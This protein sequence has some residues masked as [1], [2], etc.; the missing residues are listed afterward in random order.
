MPK[1]LL[2]RPRLH[3]PSLYVACYAVPARTTGGLQ[4]QARPLVWLLFEVALV[5]VPA[6]FVF[7]FLSDSPT[8][9]SI[10]I[11]IRIIINSFKLITTLLPALKRQ[12][13]TSWHT[14]ISSRVAKLRLVML[15][16]LLVANGTFLSRS[17]MSSGGNGVHA[18]TISTHCSSN[19][20]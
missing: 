8:S 18:L 3:G 19:R 2:S 16:A 13:L 12:Q 14:I 7:F 17:E 11:K 15:S 5:I 9:R 6:V 20:R 10:R 1:H 4:V